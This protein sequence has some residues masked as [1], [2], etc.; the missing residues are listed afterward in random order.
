MKINIARFLFF[1]A[2]CL[3]TTCKQYDKEKVET[4]LKT[5]RC[6]S[7]YSVKQGYARAFLKFAAADAVILRD[8]SSPVKGLHELG[9]TFDTLAQPQI[10]LSWEPLDGKIA[11]SS[12]LGYTYGRYQAMSV[13]QQGQ[14]LESGNYVTT[15]IKDPEGNWKWSLDCGTENTDIK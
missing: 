1:G 4:L 10:I 14:I 6:F 15:W 9:K 13:T 11:A 5:D 8:G 12:D 7:D 3:L 2:I